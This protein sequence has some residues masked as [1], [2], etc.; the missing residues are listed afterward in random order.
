MDDEECS[1]WA[2]TAA[3]ETGKDPQCVSNLKKFENNY[4]WSELTFPVSIKEIGLFKTKNDVS[5]NPIQARLF[6][7]FKGPMGSLGDPLMIS[8]TSKASPMKLCTVVVLLNT[9]QSTKKTQKI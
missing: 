5:V 6:L 2:V 7:S 3:L 9:Y 8:G 1:K 4:D